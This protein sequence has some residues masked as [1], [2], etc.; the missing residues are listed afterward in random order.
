MCNVPGATPMTFLMPPY[1][2]SLLGLP[3]MLAQG[4]P[5]DLLNCRLVEK[6]EKPTAHTMRVYRLSL[7]V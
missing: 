4:R 3:R 2:P 6:Y 5:K 1:Q 7:K